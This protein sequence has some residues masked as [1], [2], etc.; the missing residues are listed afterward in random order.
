MG[1]GHASR[2]PRSRSVGRQDRTEGIKSSG[3]GTAH[4]AC[5]T[6]DVPKEECRADQLSRA[7]RC[8]YLPLSF[9]RSSLRS[10]SFSG[11][12]RGSCPFTVPARSARSSSPFLFWH[13]SR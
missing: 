5:H 7:V 6:A 9:A 11:I 8:H 13:R 10:E 4:V 12:N 3:V 1:T 2:I